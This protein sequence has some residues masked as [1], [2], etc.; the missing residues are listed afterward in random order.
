M[1]RLFN[2]APRNVD[3]RDLEEPAAILRGGGLVGFPTETV[4]GV[5]ACADQPE[6]V[7]RLE[8]LKRRPERKPFTYHLASVAEIAGVAGE[9]P[10]AAQALIDR[11]C[12]GPLTLVLP[13]RNNAGLSPGHAK[14]SS[15]GVR[16]PANEIARL[17]IELAGGPLLVPSANPSGEPPA[18]SAEDVLRYFG[19]EIDAVVDGGRVLLGQSSTVVRF[20]EEGYEVLRE[21]IITRE[22]VHQL[23]EGRRILFVC[24]GNTCRSPL[25]A[26]IYRKLLAERLK[27]S[28]EDLGELGYRILSAGTCAAPGLRASENAMVVVRERGGDLSEHLSQSLT[29]DLLEE[30]EHVY[31]L[32]HSHYRI[33]EALIEGMEA[34]R[35]PRL[36]MLLEDGIT[37]PVG[38]DL[39]T[40]RRCADEIEAAIVRILP[41]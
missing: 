10:R 23:L 37:D 33:L 2:V 35:R 5:G 34:A 16:V 22:M 21:G 36:D 25:A 19:E 29:P 20:D 8:R 30:V 14:V 9:V 15:V 31:A 24:T 18:I 26:E 12:P 4:Y 13:R 39:D 11:Y 28:A 17:L 41:R 6:A 1:P 32:G 40:Y 3:P 27:K 38:G 7:A